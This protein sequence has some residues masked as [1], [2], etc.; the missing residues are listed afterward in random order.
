MSGLLVD[1]TVLSQLRLLSLIWTRSAS[2]VTLRTLSTSPY[3]AM[4][5]RSTCLPPEVSCH[6]VSRTNSGKPEN[7]CIPF[8]IPCE[9]P[10]SHR[11]PPTPRLLTIIGT[12]LCST[13]FRDCLHNGSENAGPS[14]LLSTRQLLLG[15]YWWVKEA[16]S[17]FCGPSMSSSSTDGS[18]HVWRLFLRTL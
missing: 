12:R 17:P 5:F 18:V 4:H 2:T 14:P 10:V 8:A 11:V 6:V 1:T 7:V 15:Q 3:P 9:G 16:P 13:I